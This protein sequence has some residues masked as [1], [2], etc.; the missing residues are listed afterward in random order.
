MESRLQRSRSGAPAA[1]R[2]CHVYS[3]PRSSDVRR[4]IDPFPRSNSAAKTRPTT[5]KTTSPPPKQRSSRGHA[6]EPRKPKPG[7]V[8]PSAWALSPG[9]AAHEVFLP[10][11]LTAGPVKRTSG[12]VLGF[13]RKK[14]TAAAAEVVR[15]ESVHRLRVVHSGVMQ[16][17]F[18]NARAEAAMAAQRSLA[19]RKLVIV[20]RGIAR[21]QNAVAEKHIRMQR[22]KLELK[23]HRIIGPQIRRL[24]QW[25]ENHSKHD[26]AFRKSVELLRAVRAPVPLVDGAHAD[27]V[28][29]QR[30]VGAAMDV[31]QGIQANFA[32]F[33]AQMERTSR[34]H[35]ELGKTVRQELH[36]LEEL[37]EMTAIV[38][39][40][41]MQERSLRANLLQGFTVS[42][43]P[44]HPKSEDGWNTGSLSGNV[45][46]SR[47]VKI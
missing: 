43:K 19:E 24:R 44:M 21:M 32:E 40:L 36:G 26:K 45:N 15:K 47:L 41:E 10:T 1:T 37:F 34:L 2:H 17:R 9:R 28:A 18:A 27:V 42:T 30:E 33:Y 13:F 46:Q 39:S 29:L 4:R 7:S 14:K 11:E 25:D 20:W 22:L 6:S 3:P 16:W 23:L 8:S 38:A 35:G 12:G 5:S 31:L